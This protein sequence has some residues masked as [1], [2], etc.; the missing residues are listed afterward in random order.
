MN[1]LPQEITLLARTLGVDLFDVLV[2]YE[3]KRELK[4]MIV[5]L[6]SAEYLITEHDKD[7]PGGTYILPLEV[8]EVIGDMGDIKV[9]KSKEIK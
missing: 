6:D 2:K 1:N 3:D 8:S 5:S 7:F 9:V 4:R